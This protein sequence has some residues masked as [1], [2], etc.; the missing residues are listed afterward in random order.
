MKKIIVYFLVLS[1]G[2]FVGCTKFEE[3]KSVEVLTKPVTTLTVSNVADSSFTMDFSTDKAGL[4]GFVILKDTSVEVAAISILSHS[5]EGNAATIMMQTYSTD[6]PGGASLDILGLMPNSYYKVAVAASNIDGVESDVE[7][8]ILKT[9]DGVGPTFKS[10]SPGISRNPLVSINT[11]IVLTF[12]EP[13]KVNPNKKFTFTYYFEG[14]SIETTLDST[15]VSGN[16]VTVPQTFAGHSGD[17]FF[18]SWEAGAV[19]DLSGNQCVERV[20]GVVNGSLVGN[21]YRFENMNFSVADK[22]IVP[23]NGSTQSMHDFVVEINFPYTIDLEDLTSDMV[24]FKYSNWLGTIT[25]EISASENCEVVNDTTLRITQPA[26]ANH[27][28]MISLYLAEGVLSD[29][30]GNLSDASDYELNWMLGD[31]EISSD[32]TPAP[33]S[34]VAS[35]MFYVYI[36]FDFAITINPDVAADAISMTYIDE[37]G[38][39]NTYPVTVYGVDSENDN[40]LIIETPQQIDFGSEVI[41]NIKENVI[42]DEDG[43]VN[44]ELQDYISWN[45]PK[46]ASSID[47]IIGQ[48]IVSGISYFDDS[49]V[50]DT[51]SI[52]LKEGS[53]NTVLITG[54]F[55][56][57]LGSSDPVEGYY[58]D[59][60]SILSIAEQVIGT[61]DDRIYTVFSNASDDYNIYGFVLEDG[62]MNTD[63]ALGVYDGS[64]GWLGFGEYL[65]EV[66]WSKISDTKSANLNFS[67]S[68]NVINNR[69][70]INRLAKGKL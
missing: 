49:V 30:Y 52:E 55:K 67:K 61:G 16:T 23:G 4:I 12:D 47:A 57:V 29:D 48:Y 24:K 27:G 42:Q 50:S 60:T 7:T 17:Y 33:G 35:Q 38:T 59:A 64:F 32:I 37:N 8:F 6:S 51:V 69:I 46:L 39:E 65:P 5:I 28:D 15:N 18:L 43:N 63:L 66:T 1:L 45:V 20:S 40:V 13:V 68:T 36:N 19:T 53:T 3:Y 44:L 54:L 14:V 22:S 11:D 9:D 58:D 21:Y 41:L 62:T 2:Y 10:S 25:T 34:I 31:F 56:S 26:M 70:K